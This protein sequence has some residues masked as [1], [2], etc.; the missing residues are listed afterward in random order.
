[1][2]NLPDS[3]AIVVH[4]L[5]TLRWWWWVDPVKIFQGGKL[6]VVTR[7]ASYDVIDREEKLRQGDQ[8]IVLSINF[9]KL[10]KK[11]RKRFRRKP[12]VFYTSLPPVKQFTLMHH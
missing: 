7:R 11:E 4:E 12:I 10:S 3:L 2:M 5:N 6:C 8:R 9:P 1:M